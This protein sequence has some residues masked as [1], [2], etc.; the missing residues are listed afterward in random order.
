[1]Y[2]RVDRIIIL[3]IIIFCA[4]SC[5]KDP[6]I[7][8]QSETGITRKTLVLYYSLS[9]Q[10]KKIAEAIYEVTKNESDEARLSIAFNFGLK[11]N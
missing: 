11:T 1:M 2:A 5:S 7:V 8:N 6:V 9:G 3:L 4:V 10:T